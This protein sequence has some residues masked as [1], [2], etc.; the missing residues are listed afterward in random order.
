MT[1]CAIITLG[2]IMDCIFCKIINGEIPSKKVYENEMK[3]FRGIL[4]DSNYVSQL[5][6]VL[7]A[8]NNY[9]KLLREE[10]Y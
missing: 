7:D 1:F 10:I 3:H 8:D 4:K 6:G 2:D 9:V 5:K